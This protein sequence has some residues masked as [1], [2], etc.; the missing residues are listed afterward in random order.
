[1][2]HY[3]LG[4]LSNNTIQ[5]MLDKVLDKHNPDI[6]YQWIEFDDSLN[7]MFTEI[8]ENNDLKV[9]RWDNKWIQKAFYSPVGKGWKIHKDGIDCK[10]ALNIALQCNESDWVRWYDN[11][12]INNLIKSEVSL[13]SQGKG[14]SRNIP[15]WKYHDIPYIDELKVNPGDVYLV[16]TDVFHSF[17]C[18]GPL[19][20]VIVQT[21]FQNNPNWDYVLESVKQLNFNDT[22]LLFDTVT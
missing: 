14:E 10:V 15:I 11:D 6:G 9:R 2:H 5:A 4:T 3:K 17:Y 7:N 8:W 12:Y 22:V 19:D 13:N 18:G 20:R 16:N 21:K 1:M